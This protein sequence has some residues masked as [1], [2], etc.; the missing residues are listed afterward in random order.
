MTNGCSRAEHPR[1][2][3][4]ERDDELGGEL[5]VGD[6]A[7]AVGAEAQRHATPIERVLSASSTAAPC[8]P[9]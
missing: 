8:G 3:A 2:G 9:S 6:A 5:G 1:R 7:D 4:A